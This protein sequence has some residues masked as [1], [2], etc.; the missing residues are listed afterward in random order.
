[1]QLSDVVKEIEKTFDT[2]RKVHQSK[3][4]EYA[5]DDTD[6]LANFKRIATNLGVDPYVPLL[7]Y[8]TKHWDSINNFVKC[9]TSD[10]VYTSSE[11][12]EGR[13]DDL[14]LYAILLKCMIAEKN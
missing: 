7:T 2:C 13:V 12:I 11:P 4:I 10:A 14:I 8:M 3:G 9:A 6:Q 1:M 5:N